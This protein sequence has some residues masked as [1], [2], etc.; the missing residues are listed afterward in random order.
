MFSY[1]CPW[2]DEKWEPEGGVKY[3]RCP[4]C[5]NPLPMKQSTYRRRQRAAK[6]L[7]ILEQ[8]KLPGVTTRELA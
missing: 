1:K 7:A 2:C 6:A 5:D 8:G 3:N 4:F